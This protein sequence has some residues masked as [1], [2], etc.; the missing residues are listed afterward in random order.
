MKSRCV[1]VLAAALMLLAACY[2]KSDFSPTESVATS[3][4]PAGSPDAAIGCS[5]SSGTPLPH[6]TRC[7]TR[8]S[9]SGSAQWTSSIATMSGRSRAS[10]SS[11]VSTMSS[12]TASASS[13]LSRQRR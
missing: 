11:S 7:S 10:R 1:L 9:S 3:V 13:S 2:K 6:C 5:T 12:T 8:S 4:R